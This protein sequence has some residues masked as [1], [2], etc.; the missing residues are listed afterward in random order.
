[1]LR[2]IAQ[3]FGGPRVQFAVE[4]ER[5]VEAILAELKPGREL[6]IT[7]SSTQAW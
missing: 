2:E 6:H 5:R 1:M 4:A 3:R 7:W